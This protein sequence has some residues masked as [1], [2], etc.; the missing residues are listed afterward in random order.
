M[1]TTKLAIALILAFESAV[2]ASA[3]PTN[4]GEQNK[5]LVRD[6]YELAFNAH[7]PTKAARKYIGDEYIR[8]NPFVPNGAA[9]F[10]DHF[11]EDSGSIR[12]RT[13]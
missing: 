4:T 7:E 8:H 2:C 13:S 11:E 5:K 12:R 6:F 1:K 3:R 10:C 9:A